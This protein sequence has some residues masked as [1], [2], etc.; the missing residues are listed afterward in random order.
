MDGKTT[1]IEKDWFDIAKVIFWDYFH[2]ISNSKARQRH[3]VK[4]LVIINTGYR[5][6]FDIINTLSKGG[7]VN[8]LNT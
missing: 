6:K 4:T 7:K 1:S 2:F 3:L 5:K 8:F